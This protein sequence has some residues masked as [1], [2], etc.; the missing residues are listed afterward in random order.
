MT[1]GDKTEVVKF[2]GSPSDAD[3]EE[4]FESQC[5]G[6]YKWWRDPAQDTSGPTTY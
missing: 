2:V 5:G 3:I 4:Y 6:V 1:K